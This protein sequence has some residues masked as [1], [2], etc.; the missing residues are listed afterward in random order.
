MLFVA[1]TNNKGKLKELKRILNQMGHEVKSQKEVGITI[2]PIEDGKTFE[3]NA[4]IKA[5]AICGEC[6]L[7][8]IADDSGIEVDVLNGA[9]GVYTARYAGVHGDDE[10]NNNK[11]LKDLLPYEKQ[12][13]TAKF[14][15]A[16]C[17]YMPNGE[18]IITKGECEGYIGFEKIGDNGFGY[19]PIFN[20]PFYNDRSYAELTDEEK[21]V[22][23]HRGKA[24]A[25]LKEK[26]SEFKG[27]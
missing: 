11:L 10:A 21:D 27:I 3:E 1:A 5:K 15:S 13:R 26:L 16:I 19:D 12:E 24:L 23:S 6:N 8:T 22:I 14:V 9:P 4:I 20:V 17:M 18:Y 2:E 25:K 7:P